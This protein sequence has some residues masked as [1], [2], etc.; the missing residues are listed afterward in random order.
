MLL[1]FIEQETN[2]TKLGTIITL[3]LGAIQIFFLLH[4]QNIKSKQE[5]DLL[6]KA[7]VLAKEVGDQMIQFDSSSVIL[8][9]KQELKYMELIKMLRLARHKF[10][11][12][13]KPLIKSILKNATLVSNY[14][15]KM[16][17][18]PSKYSEISD[19]YEG[20]LTNTTFLNE[21]TQWLWDNRQ[22]E[23]EKVLSL[24][25]SIEEYVK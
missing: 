15:R 17:I 5:G 9:E 1:L 21:E 6:L 7:A 12:K 23:A 2:I 8:D 4:D 16:R 11:R 22:K 19:C 10:P 13:F 25:N 20:T 18:S 24:A 14:N 3:L